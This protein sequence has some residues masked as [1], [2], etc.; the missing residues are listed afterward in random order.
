LTTHVM[1]STISFDSVLF[2]FAF[3]LVFLSFSAISVVFCTFMLS[4]GV[5]IHS[6]VF[7]T[8]FVELSD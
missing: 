6:T 2:N 1:F 3:M 4:L 8:S 5:V 7:V